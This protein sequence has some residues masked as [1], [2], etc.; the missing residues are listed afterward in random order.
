MR[1]NLCKLPSLLLVRYLHSHTVHTVCTEYEVGPSCFGKRTSANSTLPT[2]LSL[3]GR[4][5]GK[6]GG[7]KAL[8][9]IEHRLCLHYE[10]ESSGQGQMVTKVV[11]SEAPD[12]R[13]GLITT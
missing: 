13:K 9:L 11:I 8:I 12:R 2:P 6:A 1:Q 5:G 7:L 4:K 3:V 10:S